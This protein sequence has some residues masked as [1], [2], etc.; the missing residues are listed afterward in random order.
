MGGATSPGTRR[1]QLAHK[2]RGGARA[3]PQGRYI[4]ALPSEHRRGLNAMSP[5]IPEDEFV[6]PG[7]LNVGRFKSQYS[8]DRCAWWHILLGKCRT[9]NRDR[10]GLTGLKLIGCLFWYLEILHSSEKVGVF[11]WIDREDIRRDNPIWMRSRIT[12]GK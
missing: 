6:H 10:R 3:P 8:F 12:D 11:R 4:R 1:R 7:F 9:P 2:Q 5:V